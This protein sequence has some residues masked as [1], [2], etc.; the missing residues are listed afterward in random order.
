M[1]RQ[2]K[3]DQI[4]DIY[5]KPYTQETYQRHFI[6]SGKT[7]PEDMDTR[8]VALNL[9]FSVYTTAYTLGI[10]GKLSD[11]YYN[12]KEEI[13]N[14]GTELYRLCYDDNGKHRYPKDKDLQALYKMQCLEGIMAT[15]KKSKKME[16]YIHIEPPA[17]WTANLPDLLDDL[18]TCLAGAGKHF[19][20]QETSRQFLELLTKTQTEMKV[21]S[22]HRKKIK[23]E[24]KLTEIPLDYCI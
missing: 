16:K 18:D 21:Y 7:M 23:E 20:F 14:K 13:E 6:N 17:S 15:H 1:Y 12:I 5:G 11:F 24:K 4:L 22:Q 2:G 19:H 10:F 8:L 9:A 3:D